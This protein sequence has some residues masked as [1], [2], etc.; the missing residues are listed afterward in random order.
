MKK[1]IIG[2][3]STRDDQAFIDSLFNLVNQCEGKYIVDTIIVKDE[4]LSLAQNYIVERFIESGFDY[5]LFLDDDHSGHTVEMIDFLVGADSFIATMK[6]YSRHY[7]YSCSLY[8]RLEGRDSE[9]CYAG[10]ENGEGYQECDLT[11]FPMTLIKKELFSIINPPFFKERKDSMVSWATDREFFERIAKLGIKPI[12]CFQACLNH[13]DVT[14]E[15][16]FALREKGRHEGNNEAY[17][18]LQKQRERQLQ[19]SLNDSNR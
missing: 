10:I 12:G 2:I 16:V 1:I 14:Q 9:S 3:P 4:K 5:L 6:T 15:N 11:G 7:P 18:I 8:K 19:E 17:Y 13:Q